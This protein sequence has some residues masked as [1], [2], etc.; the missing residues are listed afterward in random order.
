MRWIK[1]RDYM[2]GTDTL[3]RLQH[4]TLLQP[5]KPSF[6]FMLQAVLKLSLPENGIGNFMGLRSKITTS[7]RSPGE[8]NASLVECMQKVKLLLLLGRKCSARWTN[9]HCRPE[10][11][12]N[13]SALPR[14]QLW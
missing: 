1:P 9:S 13:F 5:R 8:F 7:F 14:G 6:S 3:H 4:M 10:S 11:F 2:D 12:Q